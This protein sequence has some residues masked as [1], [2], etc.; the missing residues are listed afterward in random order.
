MPLEVK[1]S[2]MSHI[3]DKTVINLDSVLSIEYKRKSAGGWTQTSWHE[4]TIDKKHFISLPI[5][6]N[7][8]FVIFQKKLFFNLNGYKSVDL[9]KM[10]KQ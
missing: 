8:P 6:S 3:G 2:F 4:L 7:P 10:Y 1:Q 5:N 9:T